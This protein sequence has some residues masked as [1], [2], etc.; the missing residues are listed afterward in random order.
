L[1][2]GHRRRCCHRAE[3]PQEQHLFVGGAADRSAEIIQVATS[4][5]IGGVQAAIVKLDGFVGEV[6]EGLVQEGNQDRVA[7]LDRGALKHL[8]GGPSPCLS[9]ELQPIGVERG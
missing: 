4:F 6:D 7:P 5:R 3:L 8:V 2:A 1:P 9:Q